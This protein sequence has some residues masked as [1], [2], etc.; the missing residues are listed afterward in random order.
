[1][2]SVAFR[3]IMKPGKAPEYRQRHDAIWPELSNLLKQAGVSDYQI[4]LDEETYHLFAILKR[5][6]NHGMDSLLTHP[7]VRRWW[8]MMADIMEVLPDNEPVQVPLVQ[9]FHLE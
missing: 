5:P 6:E 4:W 3:M 2:E 7:I 9:M 8:D 1:M